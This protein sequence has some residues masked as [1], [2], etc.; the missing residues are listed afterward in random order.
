MVLIITLCIY[1]VFLFIDLVPLMKKRKWK[2][3]GLFAVIFCA[4]LV[5][6]ILLIQGVKIPSPAKPL[7]KLVMAIFGGD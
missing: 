5:I 1:I 6:S 2:E 7:E 4:S 3:F